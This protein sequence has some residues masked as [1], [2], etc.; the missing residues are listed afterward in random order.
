MFV[1][2]LAV[3]CVPTIVTVTVLTRACAHSCVHAR[4][5]LCLRSRLF[6]PVIVPMI[7]TVL[8]IFEP[9][10]TIVCVW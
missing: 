7:V 10:L 8:T 9:V 1:S 3:V 2:V 4:D 5:C 6:V